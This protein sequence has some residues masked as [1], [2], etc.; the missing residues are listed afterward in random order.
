MPTPSPTAFS[1]ITRTSGRTNSILTV[2]FPLLFILI[3]TLFWSAERIVQQETKRLE[4]DFRSLI[5]YIN[6]QEKF[7]RSLNKQNQDLSE[8]VESRTYAIQEQSLPTKLSLHLLEGKESLVAM[9]FTLACDKSLECT[10][11]PSILFSLGAYLADY[12]STFWG[13]PISQQPLYFLSMST[14]K[15]VLVFLLLALC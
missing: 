14:T 8:L 1:R 12:Y 2:T 15:L 3:A 7:L 11:V 6:E 4:V 10:K 5:G 9:P 13:D